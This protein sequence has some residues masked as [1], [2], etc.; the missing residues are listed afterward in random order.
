MDDASAPPQLPAAYYRR[1]AARVR[2]LAGEATT[3]AIKEHLREIALEYERL[4]ERVENSTPKE[5]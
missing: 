3:S 4:A 1:H 2:L 5:F